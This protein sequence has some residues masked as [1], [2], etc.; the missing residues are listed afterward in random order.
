MAR[1]R[2]SKGSSSV[3]NRLSLAARYLQNCSWDRTGTISPSS[4][5]TR[6]DAKKLGK[7]QHGTTQKGLLCSKAASTI[8]SVAPSACNP[9]I[10]FALCNATWSSVLEDNEFSS[11]VVT[12]CWNRLDSVSETKSGFC[13]RCS[14]NRRCHLFG[15]F[16]Y[17]SVSKQ[18]G[19]LV[20]LGSTMITFCRWHMHKRA[21][22]SP[23]PPATSKIMGVDAISSRS[24]EGLRSNV[25]ISHFTNF[26]CRFWF[27]APCRFL[28]GGFLL[29]PFRLSFSSDLWLSCWD[30]SDCW[31]FRNCCSI[32]LSS[33]CNGES[34]VSDDSSIVTLDSKGTVDSVAMTC[35]LYCSACLKCKKKKNDL[36]SASDI[37]ARKSA[38]QLNGDD[39]ARLASSSSHVA[40][41]LHPQSA[42]RLQLTTMAKIL[43]VLYSLC[44]FTRWFVKALWSTVAH[45]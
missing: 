4:F 27:L 22:T 7:T 23:L 6:R 19:R 45:F 29:L 12:N 37:H 30:F 8:A 13:A 44:P 10:R 41:M 43:V 2:P 39:D 28:S 17:T 21:E 25:S 16:G 33:C 24:L 26:L 3:L 5:V 38:H 42:I 11:N 20:G 31:L 1:F 9:R 34:A 15:I 35:S 40:L 14:S 18:W 36:R 32:Q